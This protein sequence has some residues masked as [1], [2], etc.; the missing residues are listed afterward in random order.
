MMGLSLKCQPS[1]GMISEHF[2]IAITASH[3]QGFIVIRIHT[4]KIDAL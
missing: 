3:K 1:S 4:G 2:E